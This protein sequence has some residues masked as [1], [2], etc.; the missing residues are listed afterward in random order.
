MFDL[1]K[2]IYWGWQ[3]KSTMTNPKLQKK[4]RAVFGSY[5]Q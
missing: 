5:Y 1:L 4:D 3:E 2:V